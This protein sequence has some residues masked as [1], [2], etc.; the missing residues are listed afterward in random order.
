MPTDIYTQTIDDTETPLRIE[1]QVEWEVI[2]GVVSGGLILVITSIKH[3]AYWVELTKDCWHSLASAPE[4]FP[5]G[6]GGSTATAE[7]KYRKLLKNEEDLVREFCEEQ[8]YKNP[9]LYTEAA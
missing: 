6:H 7:D 8:F 9:K 3:H 1:W 4:R 2:R 5:A